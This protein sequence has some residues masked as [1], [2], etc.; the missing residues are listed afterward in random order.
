LIWSG[1]GLAILAC[2]A[3]V[4]AAIAPEVKHP[5]REDIPP[6]WHAR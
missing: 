5:Y 2:A 3:L 4:E 6:W 1:A